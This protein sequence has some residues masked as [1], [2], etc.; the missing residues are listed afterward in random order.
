MFIA[1]LTDFG[2]KDYFVGAMKGVIL[3][4]N[5]EA[6]I[7]DITHEIKPQNILSA[8]FVLASCY[9][10]FPQKTIFVSVIDPG[11]GS[12]RRA[13]LV[14]T[15]NYCFIAPDNGL[16]SLVLG[17]QSNYQVFELTNPQFFNHPVSNTFH[18]RDI[19]APVAAWLSKG[20]EPNEFGAEIKDFIVNKSL[21]PEKISDKEIEGQ[22]IYIDK[23][24]NLVTNLRKENISENFIL[25]V[26]GKLISKH[27][28]FYAEAEI[29]ELFTIF[30]SAGYL[31]IVSYFNS[32]ENLLNVKIGEKVKFVLE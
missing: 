15:E 5:S 12:E 17:N 29:S 27:Q 26:N 14:E 4:I 8:G 11:V 19:F 9:Q 6:K 32:A 21:I 24:G 2:T 28:N 31:E 3:S 10:N 20:I 7:I 22:I 23:F 13:I 30:G 18:G 16:L 25:E 1:L